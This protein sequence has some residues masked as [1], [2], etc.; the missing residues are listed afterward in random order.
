MIDEYKAARDRPDRVFAQSFNLHDVLY[1]VDHEPAFG[2]QAVYLDDAS[3][4]GG[5]PSYAVA[6]ILLAGRASASWR[7]PPGRC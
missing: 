5:L 3:T 4:A 2:K 6:G 7:R 1:W